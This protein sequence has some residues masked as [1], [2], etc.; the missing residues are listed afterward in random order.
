MYT[1][2]YQSI[3]EME[4]DSE[5]D[6]D[7]SSPTKT[8]TSEHDKLSKQKRLLTRS[9]HLDDRGKGPTELEL[10]FATSI[11]FDMQFTIGKVMLSVNS[12][13]QCTVSV[14]HM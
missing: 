2:A 1:S 5:D 14:A 13:G 12:R 6:D 4:R 3:A 10:V 7:S 11:F 9:T 8:K